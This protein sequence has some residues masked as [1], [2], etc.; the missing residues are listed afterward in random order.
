MFYTYLKLFAGSLRRKVDAHMAA[1]SMHTFREQMNDFTRNF[2]KYFFSREISQNFFWDLC[3]P[4]F[5]YC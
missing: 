3:F 5:Y 4:G 2:T 1:E